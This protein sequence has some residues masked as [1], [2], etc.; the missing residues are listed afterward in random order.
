M[1]EKLPA[2]IQNLKMEC[3]ERKDKQRSKI[4]SPSRCDN[5]WHKVNFCN[6][7]K[8]QTSRAVL[9][10]EVW[11]NWVLWYSRRYIYLANRVDYT[12]RGAN[13]PSRRL[14]W[15]QDPGFPGKVK[16]VK[17]LK[18]GERQTDMRFGHTICRA[19]SIDF[20][21]LANMSAYWAFSAP[22]VF[23]SIS[24]FIKVF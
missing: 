6:Q 8:T 3:K 9:K 14:P 22:W 13:G 2:N 24:I 10:N 18:E 23:L 16:Y 4:L 17:G 21:E 1:I 15:Y 5:L 12:C 11:E 20:G 19:D 7:A